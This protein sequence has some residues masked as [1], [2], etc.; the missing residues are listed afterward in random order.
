MKLIC[1][2]N[3]LSEIINT[4][5]KAISVKTTMPILECIKIDAEGD[6]NVVITGNNIDLCIEY[7]TKCQVS[8]G[9]TIA[10]A[11]KMF[12]EIIRRLPDGNVSINVNEDNNVTKIKSGASEFN[13]QG[14]S[15]NE[16]PAPPILDELFRF[17]LTQNSLKKLIRKTISFV[18]VNEGKKPVLTGALFEIKNNYLNV[19]ASDGHR[20]AVVK[21]ELKEPWMTLSL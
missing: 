19:V 7:N 4:V 6:G 3:Q 20:L 12:G 11:S 13:I 5:Q 21:E 8:E 16:Y 1:D 14:L 17:T 9:G 18:A 15:A 10:L 2:K